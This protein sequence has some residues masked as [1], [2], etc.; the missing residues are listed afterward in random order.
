MAVC[1]IPVFILIVCVLSHANEPSSN[2]TI[3][4]SISYK[5]LAVEIIGGTYYTAHHWM[6][7][8]STELP[9][10]MWGGGARIAYQSSAHLIFSLMGSYGHTENLGYMYFTYTSPPKLAFTITDLSFLVSYKAMNFQIGAGINLSHVKLYYDS[11]L[12][13]Q[14]TTLN[15]YYLKPLISG[16]VQSYISSNTYVRMQVDCSLYHFMKIGEKGIGVAEILPNICIG[17]GYSFN[18]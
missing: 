4:S 14:D 1:E 5:S 10:Y 9:K 17:L 12:D 6:P 16:G 15:T 18:L 3:D 2:S 13:Y 8:S 11:A 7:F